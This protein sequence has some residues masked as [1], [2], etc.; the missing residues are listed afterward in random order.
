VRDLLHPA[1]LY[2]LLRSQSERLDE[3][4]GE[5][6]NVGGG[7][8]VSTSLRE[9]TALCEEV[10]GRSVPVHSEPGTSAVDIPLYI[11]DHGKAARR[12]GWRPRRTVAEIVADIHRW[13][14]D[15]EAALRPLFA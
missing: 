8:A 15:N 11:S 10:V 12:F 6:F 13:L 2:G 9:L 1:D 14:K 7:P 4:A 3:C 5:V